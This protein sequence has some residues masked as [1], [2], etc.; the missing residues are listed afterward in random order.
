MRK[1]KDVWILIQNRILASFL[2]I[3]EDPKVFTF[4]V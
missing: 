3:Y 2:A 4:K 1:N